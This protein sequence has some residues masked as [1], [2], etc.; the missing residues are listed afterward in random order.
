MAG[1]DAH[2]PGLCETRAVVPTVV[3]IDDS[4]D[5]LSSATGML[6]EEGF[7]VIGCLADPTVAVAEVCAGSAQ[8]WC[9]S[10]SSCVR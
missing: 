8:A 10:T 2:P 5:F 6:N 3:I 9:C 4:A 7:W 1:T